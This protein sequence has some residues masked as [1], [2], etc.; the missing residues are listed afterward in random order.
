MIT[1]SNAYCNACMGV[2]S[3]EMGSETDAD[4]ILLLWVVVVVPL[5]GLCSFLLVCVVF[6]MLGSLR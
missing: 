5:V 3:V 6:N 2:V 1:S 4:A